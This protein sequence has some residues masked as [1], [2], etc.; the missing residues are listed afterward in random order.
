MKNL[1]QNGKN[2]RT[3]K[4]IKRAIK[5]SFDRFNTNPYQRRYHF[6]VA[7]DVNKPIEIAQNDPIKINH[8]AYRMGKRFKL[9]HY[10]KYPYIHA[11]SHLVS[12]L[13]DRYN[14]IRTD[15]SLVVLRINRQ[16]KILLSKPCENCQKI[17]D[18][19]GLSKVY[20]SI[21]KNHFANNNRIIE[22]WQR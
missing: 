13:L 18:A 21:D 1:E 6:A 11:E 9:D 5:L 22:L 2:I 7:F 19:V 12:K 15:W 20:W 4:L 17:L 14:T 10:Q 16:G 8:K 3:A